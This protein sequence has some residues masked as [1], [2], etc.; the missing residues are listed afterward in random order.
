MKALTRS[1]GR[2][3][4]SLRIALTWIFRRHLH[5]SILSFPSLM[6]LLKKTLLPANSYWS[7]LRTSLFI[8]APLSQA[9]ISLT[10]I[11]IFRRHLQQSILSFPSLMSLLKKTLLP[12]N[13]YR[14][15][16]RTSLF[17][18]APLSQARIS[19]TTIPAS[20]THSTTILKS[21][22]GLSASTGRLR[23]HCHRHTLQYH[24]HTTLHCHHH[25]TLH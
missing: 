18:S 23:R 8:S 21:R 4:L 3:Q 20:L 19:L 10:T 22:Q 13:S 5:Q 17:I 6:T 7:P 14:S 11:P 12:A 1:S 24:R 25:R 16:L 9:R 2:L 15:P